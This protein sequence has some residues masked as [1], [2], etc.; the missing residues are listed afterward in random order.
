[1]ND[2]QLEYIIKLVETGSLN[3]VAAF[4]HTSYQAVSYQIDSMEKDIGISLFDRTNKGCFATEA[5]RLAY[6]FAKDT[7]ESYS[8]LKRNAQNMSCVRLGI[9]I[10]HIPPDLTV[11]LADNCPFQV[12]LVPIVFDNM[13]SNIEKAMIDCYL[14][15]ERDLTDKMTF[16]P[17]LQDVLGIAL[18]SSYR[19]SQNSNV[20]IKELDFQRVYIGKFG[21]KNKNKIAENIRSYF[22]SCEI[23]EDA[24]ESVAMADIYSGRGIG[25]LPCGYSFIFNDKV[26]VLPLENASLEYGVFQLQGEKK[27]NRVIKA[28]ER[29]LKEQEE[30]RR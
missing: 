30:K 13:E 16:T 29:F 15:Y 2:L 21:F 11:F 7:L 26:R 17:L 9:D 10:R 14:G 5:G 25:I 4:F 24:V 8:N 6:E 23:I 28:M 18:S 27:A 12:S 19:L 3:K 22:P 1:M 20:N